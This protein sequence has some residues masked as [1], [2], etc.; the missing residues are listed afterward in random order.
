MRKLKLQVQITIDGFIARTNG[1]MDFMVEDWDDALI[2]Y[3]AALTKPVDCILLGRKL[4]EGFIP[5]W[6]SVSEDPGNPENE[7]GRKFTQTSK[8]VFSRTLTDILGENTTV[9]NDM[10]ADVKRLKSMEGGDVIVYGGGDFVANLIQLNLIDEYHLLVN[11][12]AVGTGMAIFGK[13]E[14]NLNLKLITARAF[15]CGIALLAYQS[16][17][18]L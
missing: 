13:L 3:I 11:P 15:D 12:T 6:K 9:S 4:A 2:E 10:I 14:G 18:L 1:E 16:P 7:A 5:Y 8:V 17:N